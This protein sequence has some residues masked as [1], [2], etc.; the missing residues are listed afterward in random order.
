MESGILA[1]KKPEGLSSARVVSRV[2]RKL[3]AKKVGHTGTLDPFATGLLLCSVNQ[4]TRI[5]RFFLDGKKRYLAS[6]HLGVETDTYDPTGQVLNKA[7]AN[8]MAAIQKADIRQ[9]ADGFMGPQKQVPPS[10]SA[11]KHEGTPLYKLA[12]QGK[13]IAKPPRDIEIYDLV[14]HSIDLPIIEMEVYCSSGTYIRSIAHDLGKKLGCGGH[15]AGLS[16]TQSSHFFLEQAVDLISFEQMEK[17]AAEK[18]IVPLSDCLKFM[19]KYSVDNE[20]ARKICHG[21]KVALTEIYS[22]DL[23]PG[24]FIRLVDSKGGLLAVI[25]TDKH[26]EGYNYCCVFSP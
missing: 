8:V 13:I 20:R 18:L 22:K 21:Q 26:P 19:P 14:I 10:F 25:E 23:T 11:L 4:A 16:R 12:R 24:V 3:G 5:S 2:K 17:E 6:V 15:L 7:D 1:I 9:I